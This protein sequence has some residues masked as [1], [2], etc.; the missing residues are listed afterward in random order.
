M[1]TYYI[2]VKLED[3]ADDLPILTRAIRDAELEGSEEPEQIVVPDEFVSTARR[4][5]EA[6]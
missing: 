4:I 2:I 5:F 3:K 6:V 1:T